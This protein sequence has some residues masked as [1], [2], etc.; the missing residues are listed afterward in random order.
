VDTIG[1]SGGAADVADG[2]GA[3]LP[4]GG[5]G[6]RG[7]FCGGMTFSDTG[8]VGDAVPGVTGPGG[9]SIFPVAVWLCEPGMTT[10][11]DD[12][13]LGF[14]FASPRYMNVISFFDASIVQ[15]KEACVPR[16][17]MVARPIEHYFWLQL[18]RAQLVYSTAEL[19][20]A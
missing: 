2:H 12:L 20:A 19:C 9:G 3:L 18:R 7:I 14:V 15:T 10:A 13:I 4:G 17:P 6:V 5:G 16:K 11:S 8:R 1:L